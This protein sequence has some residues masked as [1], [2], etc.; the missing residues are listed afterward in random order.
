MGNKLI[1]PPSGGRNP[2]G[3]LGHALNSSSGM[4]QVCHC[5]KFIIQLPSRNG[6]KTAFCLY[7]D[8]DFCKPLRSAFSFVNSWKVVLILIALCMNVHKYMDLWSNAIKLSQSIRW[9]AIAGYMHAFKPIQWW[10]ETYWV[11][12]LCI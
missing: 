1:L 7:W 2:S 4:S 9:V 5:I 12:I 3:V 10:N 11:L 6:K 8:F